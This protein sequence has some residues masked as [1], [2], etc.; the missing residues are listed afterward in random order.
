[1]QADEGVHMENMVDNLFQLEPMVDGLAQSWNPT[2][3][4]VNLAN[5]HIVQNVFEIVDE[6]ATQLESMHGTF[7]AMQ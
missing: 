6:P 2:T 4:N 5:I 1:M 7:E 3:S